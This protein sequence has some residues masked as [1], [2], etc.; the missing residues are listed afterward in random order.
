MKKVRFFSVAVAVVAALFVSAWAGSFTYNMITL[1]GII[2]TGS[3][4]AETAKACV[5]L[6]GP[7]TSYLTSPVTVKGLVDVNQFCK[8]TTQCRV[9]MYQLNG[10]TQTLVGSVVVPCGTSFS[11]SPNPS[12]LLRQP[13]E[14]NINQN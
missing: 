9:L 11:T 12:V 7:G 2:S 5:T 8:P 14:G 1:N 10:A 4:T 6:T 13:A 3:K